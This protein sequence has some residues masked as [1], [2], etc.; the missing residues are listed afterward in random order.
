MT[1]CI[2][3][4]KRF[5]RYKLGYEDP[6]FVGTQDPW[7]KVIICRAGTI[8]PAGGDKLWACTHSRTSTAAVAI[9]NRELPCV[10]K[11]DGTDGINAEFIVDDAKQ[12]LKAMGAKLK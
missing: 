2:D 6:E 4:E 9:R 5:P 7:H 12:I 10:I 8:C 11:M 1:D 3:V